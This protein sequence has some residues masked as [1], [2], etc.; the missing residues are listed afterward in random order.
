MSNVFAAYDALVR[1]GQLR[2]DSAQASAA[3]LLDRLAAALEAVPVR[4]SLLWRLT[5]K[6]APP[7]RGATARPTTGR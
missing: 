3:M 4:G 6:P 1:D 7:P 5:S 2:R